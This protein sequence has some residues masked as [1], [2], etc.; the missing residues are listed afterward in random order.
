MKIHKDLN[1][2]LLK[3]KKL[4]DALNIKFWI[5]LALIIST[6]FIIIAIIYTAKNFQI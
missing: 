1:I 6:I 4:H 5:S 2:I 3:E